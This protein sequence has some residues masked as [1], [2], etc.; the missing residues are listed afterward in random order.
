M[1]A[2]TNPGARFTQTFVLA[3]NGCDVYVVTNDILRFLPYKYQHPGQNPHDPPP[4]P[5]YPPINRNTREEPG[6][7]VERRDIDYGRPHDV[8]RD[9]IPVHHMRTHPPPEQ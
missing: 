6:G 4:P 2:E 3:K 9:H 5:P 7:F 1:F 8:P